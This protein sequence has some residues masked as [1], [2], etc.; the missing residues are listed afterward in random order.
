MPHR[1]A[2]KL[3]PLG[4][5]VRAG[6]IGRFGLFVVMLALLAGCASKAP[7][8]PGAELLRDQAY[9][10][11]A[12]ALPSAQDL[13]ALSPTMRAFLAAEGQVLTPLR[14]PRRA[15]VDA[16]YRP[17][18]P[19]VAGLRLEYE[20]S[21]TRTAAEAFDARAGNCLSLVMMTAAF[22]RHLE[23]TVSYQS[24][25]VDDYYSRSGSLTLA[26]GHVNLL[27]GPR[28][29]R[30]LL[31]RADPDL[32]VVDFLSPRDIRQQRSLP[33]QEH[34]IVAMYFNN[35]AAELMAAGRLDEAYWH[36]RESLRHDP[37]FVHAAN[38]LGVVHL[39]AGHADAAEAAFRH[40][41][42]HDER[43][44]A[45]LGNLVALLRAGGRTAEAEPLA[46]RLAALQPQPPFH[47]LRLGREALAA[48]DA[49]RAV[50]LLRR[51]LRLQPE[52][53]EVHFALA[54]ALLRQGDVAG[55]QHHL[56]RA[57]EFSTRRVDQSRYEAKL[58]HLRAALRPA[59]RPG[60]P[61]Y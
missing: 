29:T 45:A 26:S 20:S 58:V 23:L 24:V 34:T 35:R 22:A 36:A 13:F 60:A 48:G 12:Q 6:Q 54:E 57:A 10:A 56:A 37:G 19:G 40:V 11:Q 42:A 15:L 46:L 52:Q 33:L 14:D 32:L 16:L 17:R 47:W 51:E 44:V 27:L 61:H 41:L 55:A 7:S 39:R 53:D 8:A 30:G 18:A 21:R 4:R 38:T 28:F 9:A 59:A 5:R 1:P 25:R 3:A 2:N 49:A 43:A 50:E 31:D